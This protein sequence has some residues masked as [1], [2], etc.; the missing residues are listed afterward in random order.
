MSTTIFNPGITDAGD[1]P[2]APGAVLGA[3]G[4]VICMPAALL[5]CCLFT[6][7]LLP[8]CATPV[9][10]QRDVVWP[11]PP[12][13]ARI[14]YVRAYE[15]TKHFRR[16]AFEEAVNTLAGRGS[17]AAFQRPYGVA[18]DTAGTVYVT[19]TELHDVVVF[20]R[21]ERA[22]RRLGAAR[23][24][25]FD[26]PVGVTV[27]PSGSVI[28]ADSKL[29]KV[30]AVSGAGA[31]LRNYE[32]DTAFS[33]PCGVAYDASTGQLYVVDANRHQVSVFAEDGRFLFR[34]GKRGGGQGEFNFPTHVAAR[35][36]RVYIVDSM[37][38][39]VEA[40]DAKGAYLFTFGSLGTTPGH[41]SRPKGIAVD[42]AGRICVADAAFDNYQIFDSTGAALMFLGESGNGIGQFN[43]P[44]GIA[45]DDGGRI[46]VADQLNA[47]LQEFQFLATQ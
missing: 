8:G 30:F 44:A 47:R 21:R 28:V 9:Q 16:G 41:F 43:L 10:T 11:L 38:G 19:D 5:L 33:S 39:R 1:C 17:D 6:M 42:A 25:R 23:E 7:A 22:V 32:S 14:R 3:A 13:Q 45:I 36:G 12:E 18:V 24:V 40:F 29:R 34:F 35:N 27:T 15:S 31:F 2:V 20:D 37:N 46:Y 4:T 26:T